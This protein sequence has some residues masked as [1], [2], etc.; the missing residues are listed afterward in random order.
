MTH[1]DPSSS[2]NSLAQLRLVADDAPDHPARLASLA[3][4]SRSPQVLDALLECAGGGPAGMPSLRSAGAVPVPTTMLTSE[5]GPYTVALIT[6]LAGLGLRPGS[7]DSRL[8]LHLTAAAIEQGEPTWWWPRAATIAIQNAVLCGA[9]QEATDWVNRL[10]LLPLANRWA[11]NADVANPYLADQH[12]NRRSRDTVPDADHA[13]WETALSAPFARTGL[14]PLQVDRNATELFDGLGAASHPGS[15]DGPPVTVVMPT[16]AP[17]MG[18]LT[19]VNSILAQSYG[20]LEILLVDDC[21]G[22]QF[23]EL[24][25][26]AAAL[27][28]RITLVRMPANGGSYLGRNAAIARSTGELVT[29]Q[30]GDDWS[31]PERIALQVAAL[32]ENPSGAASVSRAIRAT[33]DL[34]YTW[35]GFSPQRDNASSLMLT[36][37]TLHRLGPFQR[38]RKG[39]DSEYFKRIEAV[40]A[41]P[42]RVKDALA[43]TRL[44][45]GSLSRADFQLDWHVPD[46]VNYRNVFGHWHRTRAHEETPVRVGSDDPQPFPPPRSFLRDLPQETPLQEQFDLGYLLDASLPGPMPGDWPAL[47]TRTA[48]GTAAVIH[49]EDFGLARPTWEPFVP[50]LLERVQ[51]GAVTLLST[52]DTAHLR[53]L[54]VLT[55]ASLEFADDTGVSF[56]ADRVLVAAPAPDDGGRYVDLMQVSD[57]C[58]EFFGTSPE[59]VALD[60]DAQQQWSADGWQLPLLQDVTS[61]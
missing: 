21:S 27:D 57:T 45:A 40:I 23:T 30:D 1:P 28:D 10:P 5:T 60:T 38:V 3:L 15:I 58:R 48:Y 54:V 47:P 7:G 53:T 39:A 46:R 61:G 11:I 31:H 2:A 6:A 24:Y 14:A 37:D 51:T 19:A 59:W 52:T 18:L 25:E 8:A 20:H 29:F 49:R 35:L 36:R 44:R 50:E 9:Y 26:Q 32:R 17:D 13:A 22:E 41:E 34:A 12:G 55:P 43:V 16:Y 4:R 42:L 33:D 56:S